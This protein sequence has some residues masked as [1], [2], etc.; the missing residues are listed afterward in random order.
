MGYYEIYLF[1]WSIQKNSSSIVLQFL[2]KTRFF[3]YQ[4]VGYSFSNKWRFSYFRS[5]LCIE[6]IYYD[7]HDADVLKK[8]SSHITFA[9]AGLP[10][11]SGKLFSNLVLLW[12]GGDLPSNQNSR[13]SIYLIGS[14][15]NHFLVQD[16][17]WQSNRAAFWVGKFTKTR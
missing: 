13:P 12:W 2:H 4:K 6:F 5:I 11:D 7:L 3:R 16:P 15:F 1:Q 17:K 10:F 8:V 14:V 9:L